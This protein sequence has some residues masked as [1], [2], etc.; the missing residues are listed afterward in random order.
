LQ[1]LGLVPQPNAGK[2]IKYDANREQIYPWI[3]W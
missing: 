3:K 1:Q 2:D